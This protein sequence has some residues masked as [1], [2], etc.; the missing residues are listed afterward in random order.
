MLAGSAVANQGL[1]QAVHALPRD[2]Y[3]DLVVAIRGGR[4]RNGV[5]T[6]THSELLS[7]AAILRMVEDRN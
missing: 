4:G 5:G 3:V 1:C 6:N 7:L 2:R